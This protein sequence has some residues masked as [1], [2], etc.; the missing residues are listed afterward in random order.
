MTTKIENFTKIG[1]QQGFTLIELMI[2]IALAL[3][4]FTGAGGVY[5]TTLSSNATMVKQQRFEQTTQAVMALITSEIRK[6]GYTKPGVTLT[7]QVNGN[8]Y[9]A[10]TNCALLSHSTTTDD[11]RFYGFKAVNNILYMYSSTA[12]PTGTACTT[13]VT[14]WLAVTDTSYIKVTQ[15]WFDTGKVDV[16]AITCTG[17]P[18]AGVES[19]PRVTLG[20]EDLSTPAVKRCYQ[21]NVQRRNG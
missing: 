19:I 3:I 9:F 17:N 15:L 21:F 12:N 14:G 7:P 2:G 4:L 1:G 6:A 13:N 11:E 18:V 16:S 10:S 5:V 20:V 8:T